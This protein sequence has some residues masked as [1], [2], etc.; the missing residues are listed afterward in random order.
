MSS[1]AFVRIAAVPYV[2]WMA[3][4]VIVPLLFIVRLC[5]YQFQRIALPWKISP[6]SAFTPRCLKILF[7]RLVLPLWSAF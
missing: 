7:C 4:F 6:T 2:V 5:I 1:K 3:I